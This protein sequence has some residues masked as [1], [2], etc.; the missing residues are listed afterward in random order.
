LFVQI[1]RHR[2]IMIDGNSTKKSGKRANNLISERIKFLH[3]VIDELEE[4]R[5]GLSLS[6][7]PPPPSD[8]GTYNFL[9]KTNS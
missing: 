9:F 5:A 3:Y 4:G 6:S 7:C 8:A 1:R 2:G